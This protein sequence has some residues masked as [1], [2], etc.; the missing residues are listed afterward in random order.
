MIERVVLAILL[1][2]AIIGAETRPGAA[3]THFIGHWKMSSNLFPTLALGS[4]IALVIGW[5]SHQREVEEKLKEGPPRR[6]KRVG[7]LA[8]TLE[9]RGGAIAEVGSAL[10]REQVP[11]SDVLDK[12]YA[13][14]KETK[15]PADEEL[16]VEIH[17]AIEAIERKGSKPNVFG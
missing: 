2:G 14:L 12:A 3:Q 5:L 13:E 10:N 7:D 1:G 8:Q 16:I 17:S 9:G 15:E 4:G 11:A 6:Q